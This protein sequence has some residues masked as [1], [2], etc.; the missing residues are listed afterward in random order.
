[1]AG[2]PPA[3]WLEGL[4]EKLGYVSAQKL[5]V[6]AKRE[7]REKNYQTPTLEDALKVTRSSSTH[8]RF[9]RVKTEGKVAALKPGFMQMDLLSMVPLQ[10]VKANLKY[11]N[12]LLVIDVFTRK[13][14]AEKLR[15]KD[16]ELVVSALKSLIQN[17]GM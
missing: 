4:N 16:P 5:L 3:G 1:M 6:A 2:Q 14:Y 13:I 9:D 15:G 7:A 17:D 11:S 8:Q 12:I 10:D